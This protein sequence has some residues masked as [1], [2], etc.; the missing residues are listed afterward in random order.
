MG[1]DQFKTTFLKAPLTAK[2]EGVGG[3][4]KCGP[5]I[6]EIPTCISLDLL[7]LKGAALSSFAKPESNNSL[8]VIARSRWSPLRPNLISRASPKAF[9]YALRSGDASDGIAGSP[10][11]FV[12]LSL[13]I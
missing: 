9:K 4:S 13:D 12:G 5:F 3:V 10:G 7:G 11:T 1:S 2:P 6:E 8:K